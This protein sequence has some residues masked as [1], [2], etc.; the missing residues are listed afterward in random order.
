VTP[1]KAADKILDGV[2]RNRFLIYT[3]P[4]IRALYAFKRFAPWPYSEVMKQVNMMF[5]RALQPRARA[6][7]QLPPG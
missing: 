4:D 6:T 7:R 5:S 3:S 2:A 1:E